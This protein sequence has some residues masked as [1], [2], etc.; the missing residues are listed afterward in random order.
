[1]ENS[2]TDLNEIAKALCS[3]QLEIK[4]AKKD[5]KNPFFKSD[6]STLESI[7]DSCLPALNKHAIAVTQTMAVNGH[8]MVLITTLLH[9]SGQWISSSYP[10]NPIKSDPQSLG[11]AISYARRY[12]LAAIAG[13][14]SA[15]DDGEVAMGRSTDTVLTQTNRTVASVGHV[16]EAQLARLFAIVKSAHWT[17]EDV[18]KYLG[19]MGLTSTKE[20]GQMQYKTLCERIVA[21]PR[22]AP[23]AKTNNQVNA[24][25]G[26]KNKGGEGNLS[27]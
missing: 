25:D 12:S 11:S 23:V 14:V 8:G 20:L 7:S 9:S 1:M 18:K 17:N 22:E 13:V 26:S 6:Y 16:T 5:A 27:V 19:D 21:Y 15:D 2:S 3:A 24:K 10:V 4:H